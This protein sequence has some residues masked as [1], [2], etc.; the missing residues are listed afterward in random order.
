MTNDPVTLIPWAIKIRGELH[1]T[2]HAP[3]NEKTA[4]SWAINYMQLEKAMGGKKWDWGE[5]SIKRVNE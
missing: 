1:K 2:F 3:D 4:M 5:I